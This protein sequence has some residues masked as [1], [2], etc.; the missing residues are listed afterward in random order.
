MRQ[1]MSSSQYVLVNTDN[2]MNTANT[3]VFF[4]VLFLVSLI[5]EYIFMMPFVKKTMPECTMKE[6]AM[7]IISISSL[8]LSCQF[9]IIFIIIFANMD[10]VDSNMLLYV[11]IFM[12]NS[13]ICSVLIKSQYY[14]TIWNIR[15]DQ[16]IAYVLLAN[17]FMIIRYLLISL[18]C[19]WFVD[20]VAASVNT[21][22]TKYISTN[23]F[24]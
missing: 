4:L 12:W 13:E 22:I 16:C 19:K 3:P 6:K 10:S 9:I 8:I 15:I 21:G 2:I 14:S 11:N 24:V 1:M 20:I 7:D 18:Y 23:F 17:V 5:L